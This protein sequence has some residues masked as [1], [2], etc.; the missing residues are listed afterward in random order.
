MNTCTNHIYIYTTLYVALSDYIGDYISDVLE[1]SKRRAMF[2]HILS[3][4][5]IVIVIADFYCQMIT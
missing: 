2:Y 5:F 3:Q 4:I 1:T